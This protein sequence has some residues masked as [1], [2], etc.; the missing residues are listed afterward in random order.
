MY[1]LHKKINSLYRFIVLEKSRTEY[2]K[3]R[4]ELVTKR[5][6]CFKNGVTVKHFANCYSS[7]IMGSM[8]AKVLKELVGN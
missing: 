5:K 6:I 2:K 7:A 8:A 4:E 1:H 3:L